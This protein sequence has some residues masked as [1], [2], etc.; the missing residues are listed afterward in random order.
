M[1]GVR[2][3]V[4]LEPL[5]GGV[6][7]GVELPVVVTAAD[8]A[9]GPY[10]V[11]EPGVRVLKV[12]EMVVVLIVIALLEV[13]PEV[14]VKLSVGVVPEVVVDT[15]LV[16]IGDVVGVLTVAEVV[17]GIPAVVLWGVDTEGVGP[18]VV[19]LVVDAV[20]VNGVDIDG[21]DPVGLLGPEVVVVPGLEVVPCD[22]VGGLGILVVVVS[23]TGVSVT[24]VVLVDLEGVG[25]EVVVL[26]VDPVLVTSE[27]VA[28]TG[29]VDT[30]EVDC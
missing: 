21:G 5:T 14:V 25:P 9:V 2:L 24:G 13:V 23:W 19:V 3:V 28:V 10:V 20:P 22:P 18:E 17:V 16:D 27:V 15:G 29:L 7:V 6:A 1:V 8:V 30:G 11:V 26:G 4:E 12:V